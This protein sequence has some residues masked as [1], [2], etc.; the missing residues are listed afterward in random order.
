MYI[1]GR[2]VTPKQLANFALLVLSLA[3]FA[4][5]GHDALD[6][7]FTFCGRYGFGC[8]PLTLGDAGMARYWLVVCLFLAMPAVLALLAWRGLR[9]RARDRYR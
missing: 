7:N 4:W 9:E 5:L 3:A 6:G 8:S 1:G 2:I